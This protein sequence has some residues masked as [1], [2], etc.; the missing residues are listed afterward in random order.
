MA[1]KKISASENLNPFSVYAPSGKVFASP[2]GDKYEDDY[3]YVVQE[4]G[5]KLLEVVG[6]KDVYTL[7]QEAL[8]SVYLRDVVSRYDRG[9]LTQ[10]EFE[11][12]VRQ[13]PGVEFDATKGP[14]TLAEMLQAQI[15]A[16]NMFYSLP[17][18][19][20]DKWGQS[21]EKFY[22]SI[23]DGSA[24]QIFSDIQQQY[25]ASSRQ[26]SDSAIASE[27]KEEEVK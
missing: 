9:L 21:K 2:S 27:K 14:Q 1:S 18:D 10:Q 4:D 23:L 24:E 20:R 15:D 16:E 6:K 3:A 13:D 26:V 19:M 25:Y 11:E 17:P 8:S 5:T 7:K 22:S 12:I